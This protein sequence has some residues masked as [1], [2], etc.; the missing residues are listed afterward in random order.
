MFAIVL[1]NTALALALLDVRLLLCLSNGVLQASVF[2]SDGFIG[3]MRSQRLLLASVALANA[4]VV[5]ALLAF[6]VVPCSS[7]AFPVSKSFYYSV[8][9]LARDMHCAMI[10]VLCFEIDAL[11]R[12]AHWRRFLHLGEQVTFTI[13]PMGDK[14][15][16]SLANFRATAAGRFQAGVSRVELD[17][18]G[19]LVRSFSACVRVE[20]AFANMYV[21]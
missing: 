3:T 8:A 6:G 16:P 13:R 2:L 18:S 10:I 1:A 5:V 12:N 14:D 7:L 20:T 9:Q 11:S 15:V 19:F 17:R 4:T 21:K